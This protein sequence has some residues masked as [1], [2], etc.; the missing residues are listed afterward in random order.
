MGDFV[1]S[2]ITIRGPLIKCAIWQ[3]IGSKVYKPDERL[4]NRI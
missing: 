4:Q 1:V 3:Y 2:Q